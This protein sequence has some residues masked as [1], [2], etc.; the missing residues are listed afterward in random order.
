VH[1]AGGR[2]IIFQKGSFVNKLWQ[3]AT[4]EAFTHQYVNPVFMGF[5]Q[6]SGPVMQVNL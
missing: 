6:I 3:P 2:P 5:C 1:S 4:F